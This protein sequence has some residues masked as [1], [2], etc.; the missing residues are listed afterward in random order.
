[1][2]ANS[3]M[4]PVRTCVG[5]RAKRP[6]T[7]MLRCALAADGNPVISRT[8]AGRGAWLC[9]EQATCLHQAIKRRGLDRAWKCP[10]STTQHNILTIAYE[11]MTK[12][13]EN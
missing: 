5:C 3:T 9:T 7:E 4:T 12:N 11:A 2:A 13:M 10:V 6:Q 8:A 1:M